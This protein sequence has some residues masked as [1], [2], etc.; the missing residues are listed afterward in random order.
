MATFFSV[1]AEIISAF[2]M[3]S[4]GLGVF[5]FGLGAFIVAAAAT[6]DDFVQGGHYHFPHLYIAQRVMHVVNDYDRAYHDADKTTE[7]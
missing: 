6:D 1:L 2:G 5:A 7:E 3:L 4:V